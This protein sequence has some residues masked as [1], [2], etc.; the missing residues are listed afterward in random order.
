MGRAGRE[1]AQA[2]FGPDAHAAQVERVYRRIVERC[3]RGR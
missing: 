1:R 2:L 3:E